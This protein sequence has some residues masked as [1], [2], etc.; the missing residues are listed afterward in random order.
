MGPNGVISST[1]AAVWKASSQQQQQCMAR[2]AYLIYIYLICILCICIYIYI[3]YILCYRDST[4]TARKLPLFSLFWPIFLSR[5]GN[6]LF[7]LFVCCAV[8]CC[9]GCTWLYY[10]SSSSLFVCLFVCV[11]C[12]F[13]PRSPCAV[14]RRSWVRCGFGDGMTKT[15]AGGHGR[16][17]IRVHQVRQ[18]ETIDFSFRFAVVWFGLV[19]SGSG[20]FCLLWSDL[21]WFGSQV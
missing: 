3:Y 8:L 5:M 10:S 18:G 14:G 20:R 11:F 12:V 2:R 4:N 1:V 16:P 17:A 13:A 19:W 7:V 21:V 9:A 6:F 15:D